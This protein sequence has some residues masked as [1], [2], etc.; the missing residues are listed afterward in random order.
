MSGDDRRQQSHQRGGQPAAGA[1]GWV[2][3]ATPPGGSCPPL[4]R[5]ERQVVA[6]LA[7]GLT[8]RQIAEA[9]RIGERTV[10]TYVGNSLRKLGLTSRTQVAIWAMERRGSAGHHS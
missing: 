9:L 6:L 2:A 4:T 5:R 3:W 7:Q 10:E 8:N 1:A